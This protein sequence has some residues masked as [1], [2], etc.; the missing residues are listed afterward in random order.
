MCIILC[1]ALPVRSS[2]VGQA[3]AVVGPEERSGPA[4]A[5][6]GYP[7]S[8]PQSSLPGPSGAD[9]PHRLGEYSVRTV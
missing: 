4:G 2:A 3:S 8:C 1:S 9:G 6:G 5:E 7:R